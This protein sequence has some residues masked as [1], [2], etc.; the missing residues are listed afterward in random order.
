MW[1]INIRNLPPVSP[2]EYCPNGAISVKVGQL[3]GTP[4]AVFAAGENWWALRD[5]NPQ[6]KDYELQRWVSTTPIQCL[7][8]AAQCPQLC[9]SYTMT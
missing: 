7:Q 4:T 9:L 2:N 5:S 1:N 6:P 8:L 3:M